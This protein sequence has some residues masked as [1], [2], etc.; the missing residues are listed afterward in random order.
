MTEEFDEPKRIAIN[1]V[2]T[3]KGDAGSTQ[4][5]GGQNVPKSSL[6]IASYGDVDELNS[7]VGR[8]RDAIGN[9]GLELELYAEMLSYEDPSAE[10]LAA[11]ELTPAE[12]KGLSPT[13]EFNR[14]EA[15][16][17]RVQHQ[18]FNLGSI[19][20]TLPEDVHPNQPRIRPEDSEWL[21]S[22]MDRCNAHLEPL[23]SFI[24]P[25][26]GACSVELHVC[27]T[28]AR[29]VERLVCG[30]AEQEEV[31]K[32]ALIYLNRLSDAFF[33]WSRWVVYLVGGTETLWQPNEG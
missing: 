12:E 5:V 13:D 28:V 6:R 21:E 18:L 17:L 15:I 2:Y 16:L 32:A 7:F 25:G 10:E 8:A 31:D 22:E 23:R 33:V 1:R 9:V 20:A 24:L 4:L 27:R 19:L 3:G 14:L 11:E 29:R 26:G 30:L